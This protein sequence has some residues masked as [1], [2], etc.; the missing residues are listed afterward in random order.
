MKYYQS[1]ITVALAAFGLLCGAFNVY[2]QGLPAS[3]K[4]IP[5]E[6]MKAPVKSWKLSPRQQNYEVPVSTRKN[7][8][9]NVTA[10]AASSGSQ[11]IIYAAM[12]NRSTWGSSMEYGIYSFTPTEY[13][14]DLVKRDFNFNANGGAS[15][16]GDNNYLSVNTTDFG[17]FL[18]IEMHAYDTDS[19]VEVYNTMGDESIIATDMTYC[20]TDNKVYGCFNNDSGTGYVF[21]IFDQDKFERTAICDLDEAWIACG[22]DANGTIYAVTLSGILITADKQTGAINEI[23]NTG[24]TSSNLTSG[25]IDISTGLFYVATCNDD[26]SALYQVDIADATTQL[27]YNMP[28]GEEL[29]GMYIARQ[30]LDPSAPAA[31][32]DLRAQFADNSLTGTV[33]FTLPSTTVGGAQ[34]SG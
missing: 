34:G 12:I 33:A 32:T 6:I 30:A 28:D 22:A 2:S 8:Y 15:Y 3:G 9:A 14:F 16:I 19:W 21:G 24:L 26:G 7:A 4:V 27:L 17:G 5:E 13:S 20:E 23:G 31:V 29:V 11:P 10:D 25:A 1:F 18:W